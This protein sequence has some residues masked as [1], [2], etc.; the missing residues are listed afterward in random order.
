MDTIVVF[1]LGTFGD[2]LPMQ[3]L[4]LSILENEEFHNIIIVTNK[5]N[6]RHTNPTFPRLSYLFV[7]SPSISFNREDREHFFATEDLF[8]MCASLKSTGGI[9]MVIANLF[10]LA[11]FVL[12][13]ALDVP[14][15]LIVLHA[16]TGS[17]PLSFR[18]SLKTSWPTFYEKLNDLSLSS[19]CAMWDDYEQFLW[20]TLSSEYDDLRGKLGLLHPDDVSYAMPQRPLVLLVHSPRM[21]PLSASFSRCQVIGCIRANTNTHLLPIPSPEMLAFLDNQQHRGHSVVCIDFGSL[22]SFV[23]SV[24]TIERCDDSDG[25]AIFLGTISAIAC[26]TSS[27][28]FVIVCHGCT[29]FAEKIRAVAGNCDGRIHVVDGD[30]L[31]DPLFRRC[32]AVIHH[33][34]AGTLHSCLHVGIPQ[35]VMPIVHDQFMNATR[36]H[37]MRLGPLPLQK[38]DLF[39]DQDDNDDDDTALAT[40]RQSLDDLIAH[41][42]EILLDKLQA[43]TAPA[44]RLRCGTFGK[45]IRDDPT[46]DGLT[47]ATTLITTIL[48]SHIP[49]Q[50]SS[51]M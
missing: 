4:A 16:P 32:T 47:Q 2:L 27:Y 14:C 50:S 36:V 33:G 45:A 13:T 31:H 43:A 18:D 5:D 3:L 26:S 9:Q 39:P 6:E 12:A 49:S 28:S 8:N 46:E 1:A 41:A 25:L 20:P 21:F 10:S 15:T 51:I 11:G 48:H 24:A 17:C 35:I 34:G 7:S 42:T 23:E 38:E 40:P 30:V 29:I 19:S 44:Q 22:T 37:E